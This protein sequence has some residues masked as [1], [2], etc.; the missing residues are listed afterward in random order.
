MS[1]ADK[2]KDL[3]DTPGVYIMRDNTGKVIY[4]GKAVVLKNRVRQYFHNSEKP[5]KVQTMVD[6][7][8]DFEYIITRT[9][10]DALALENNLIKKYKPHYNIL[11]K[12][13][14]TSPYIKIDMRADYPSI[15]VTRRVKRDGA[16]Y[17]G[18]F[19]GVSVHDVISVLQSVY[20]LRTC[21]G[22]LK[23]RARPC[24]NYDLG[25]C[26]APC[27]ERC[28]RDEYMKAINDAASFLSGGSD[29]IS[30]IITQKMTEAAEKEDFERAISYRNQLRVVENLKS[31][32]VGAL[33]NTFNIDT[34][35]YTDNGIYGAV[36]VCIVR[37]GKMM[38]V[39]N[40]IISEPQVF[41][42]DMTT[43]LPQ[44]YSMTNELPDE[45]CLQHEI[46]TT[47]LEE[48]FTSVFSKRPAISFPQKGLRKKLLD[49]AERNCSDYLLKSADRVKRETDMTLG[50]CERLKNLFGI[51]SARRIECYDISNI[52][53]VDKV[54]SQVVFIDGKADKNQYRRYRIRTVEG[55]DDFRSMYETL[56]RR[57]I[58]YKNGDA[59]FSELPDLIVIDGGLEQ[60]EFA[61][62]AASDVGVSVPMVGLAKK[63]EEIYLRGVKEPIR[64]TRDD[65]GLRLMQRVRD[66][67]HRFAI[68][69]HRSIRAKRYES[70]LKSVPGVG[71]TTV[72]KVLEVFNTRSIV[73]ATAE[74]IVQKAGINIKAARNIYEYYHP[75]GDEMRENK[76]LKYKLIA[77]DMDGTLLNDELTVSRRNLDAIR[78][79][80]EAGGIFTISTGR[81]PKA[82][83]RYIDLLDLKNHP[84]KMVCNLGCMIVDSLTLEPEITHGI[85]NATAAELVRFAEKDSKY[86]QIYAE[87]GL[88]IKEVTEMTN[89]YCDAVRI[90]AEAVGDLSKF[91]ESADCAVVKVLLIV[92]ERKVKRM[93][94]ELNAAFPTLKFIQST[95]PLLQRLKKYDNDFEPT[96]IECLIEGVDKGTGLCKLAEHYG[97]KLSETIAF[98]DSFNDLAMIKAAGLGVAMGN[99]CEPIKRLADVVAKTNN[100]DG[101]AE[102]IEK[103]ALSI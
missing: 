75:N 8:A 64:L 42:G 90:E 28:D 98:G 57:L 11:L 16:R 26:L 96:M 54:A 4:V 39:K 69:Y 24:L 34:F 36:S 45:I 50:A 7:I 52:S 93:I 17:F 1:I 101:V 48:Y 44:Y 33:G 72:R 9:E 21:S 43:F 87:S 49:T 103:Y 35:A 86:V 80:R 97:V 91:A 12:D 66:E 68:M 59:G 65:Y 40:Y 55:S 56:T 31:K 5:V 41:G 99:A 30:G 83:T 67:A 2:L 38:G 81:A 22:A 29:D 74:E 89:E 73:N 23:K 13:D 61:A 78:A 92:D 100:E 88:K 60:V 76:E 14:K 70:E 19:I 46:D 84:V 94:D 95:A 37:G 102:I 58:H 82:L 10:K 32:V 27:C 20:K 62:Q 79:Y 71:A 53:G 6:N 85:P 47:A 51:P 63:D 18:P 3:P 15:E 77:V 25:I